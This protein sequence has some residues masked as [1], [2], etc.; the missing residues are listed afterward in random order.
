MAAMLLK[1]SIIMEWIEIFVPGRQKNMFFWCGWTL[2]AIN[3]SFYIAGIVSENLSCTPFHSIW[4]VTVPNRKCFNIKALDVAAAAIDLICDIAITILPQQ[5]IW[6]LQMSTRT[7]LGISLLFSI[8]IL[9]VL[10]LPPPLRSDCPVPSN[11]DERH[12]ALAASV[13][14]L[15]ANVNYVKS[16]D[17]TYWFAPVALWA[18]ARLVALFLIFC[19]PSIPKALSDLGINSFVMASVRLVT[20]RSSVK[21]KNSDGVNPETRPYQVP[22]NGSKGRKKFNH[23]SILLTNLSADPTI[24]LPRHD[25]RSEST[26]HLRP[27][28]QWSGILRTNTIQQQSSPGTDVAASQAKESFGRQHPWTTNHP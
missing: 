18:F 15:V 23:D 8:G 4:D 10:A 6:R 7:R 2:V 24:E 19:L 28:V 22:S 1:A 25:A 3:T 14:R 20:G 17:A 5:V 12:S 9:F 16:A 21:S 11:A 26:E 13:C 27:P